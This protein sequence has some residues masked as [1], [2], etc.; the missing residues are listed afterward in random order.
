MA[1]Q[2]ETTVVDGPLPAWGHVLF[3]VAGG[4]RGEMISHYIKKH[5]ARNRRCEFAQ[6]KIIAL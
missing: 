1:E 4:K 6:D 2:R 5:I 3:I